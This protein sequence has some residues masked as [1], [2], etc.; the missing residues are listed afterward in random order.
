M[1]MV[2]EALPVC[3]DN[4]IDV[5]LIRHAES[6]TNIKKHGDKIGGQNLNTLLTPDGEKQASMLGDYFKEKNFTFVEFYRST[7][8]RTQ[9]TARLCFEAM[10]YS[11]QQIEA[12]E[13]LLEFCA[14]S[15][16]GQDRSIYQREDIRNG[17]L[18]DNWTYVPGDGLP[19]ENGKMGE[20]QQMVAQR[21]QQWIERKVNECHKKGVKS[22]CI[23][24]HG[25]A[26]KMFLTGTFGY[27][28]RK[29]AFKIPV[30]NTSITHLSYGPSM[31]KCLQ[32][33][34]TPHL[35]GSSNDSCSAAF[36]GKSYLWKS[37]NK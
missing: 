7:A 3:S 28:P 9:E 25:F 16:E 13:E 26:I 5:Y 10:G 4:T 21:M 17:L 30:N 32:F 11:N 33:N 37:D 1:R 27:K 18:Q 8:W 19:N 14:G 29:L 23:F 24:T 15:W 22:I 20:S 12:D 35:T 36:E 31:A 34:A 6:E 2:N